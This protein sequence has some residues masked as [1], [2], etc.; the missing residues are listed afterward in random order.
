M[1][2]DFIP[3]A[4]ALGAIFATDPKTGTLLAAFIGLQNLPESF[5]S[6]QDLIRSGMKSK[7]ALGILFALSF[8]GVIGALLGYEFLT[9]LP[10]VTAFLMVIAGGGILYLIFQDIA[11]NVKLKRAWIAV[12]GANLGFVIGMIGEKLIQ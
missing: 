4:I 1:M 5:N 12:L 9:N 10:E 3:E 8:S 11:P 6:Y 7:K 2:L